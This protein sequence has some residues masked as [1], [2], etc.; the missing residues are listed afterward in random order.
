M[1]LLY[2]GDLQHL[3]RSQIKYGDYFKHFRTRILEEVMPFA[4]KE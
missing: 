3:S 2:I 1:A 4:P